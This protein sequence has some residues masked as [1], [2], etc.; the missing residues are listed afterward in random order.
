MKILLAIAAASAFLSISAVAE[1][2]S[3]DVYLG[4]ETDVSFE[5]SR[6]R[7]AAAGY[8]SARMVNGN[9]LFLS[10]FDMDGSEVELSVNPVDG[11]FTIIRYVH[12]MDQ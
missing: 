1:D 11:V 8:N 7:L 10:A 3:G 12:F 2:G 5:I 6:D 4:S 9:P